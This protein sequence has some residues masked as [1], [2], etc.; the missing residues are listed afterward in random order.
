[1]VVVFCPNFALKN[2]LEFREICG[3]GLII[4]FLN[5]FLLL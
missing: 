1:M 2:I 4:R 5:D 3:P